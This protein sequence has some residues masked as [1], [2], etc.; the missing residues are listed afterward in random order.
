MKVQH[1]LPSQ[2]EKKGMD[3]APGKFFIPDAASH[4][5]V[6]F[7]YYNKVKHRFKCFKSTR[8]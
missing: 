8:L 4:M 5:F 3:I 6:V 2:I 1:Q 7:A